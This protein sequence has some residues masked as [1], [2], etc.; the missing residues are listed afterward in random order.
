M[1][2]LLIFK[3]DEGELRAEMAGRRERC[4]IPAGWGKMWSAQPA[5]G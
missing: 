1:G 5:T 4:V 2:R 3:R